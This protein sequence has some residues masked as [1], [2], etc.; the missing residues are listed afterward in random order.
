MQPTDDCCTPQ[1][2][3]VNSTDDAMVCLPECYGFRIIIRGNAGTRVIANSDTCFDWQTQSHRQTDTISSF[4][5]LLVSGI[6]RRLLFCTQRSS[7]L[8]LC[9]GERSSP[10]VIILCCSC[11]WIDHESGIVSF[12]SSNRREKRDLIWIDNDDSAA[13]PL[14]GRRETRFAV[15]C[16]SSQGKNLAILCGRVPRRVTV[17]WYL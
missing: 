3:L 6:R 2:A 15:P 10:F 7:V 13:M 14:K 5:S 12:V 17:T 8:L 4:S 1:D 11:C 9:R 16:A